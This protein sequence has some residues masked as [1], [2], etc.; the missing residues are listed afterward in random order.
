MKTE[1]IENLFSLMEDIKEMESLRKYRFDQF[2]TG[3][4]LFPLY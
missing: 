1:N 4:T 3:I 2:L